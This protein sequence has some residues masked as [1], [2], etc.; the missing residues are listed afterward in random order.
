MYVYTPKQWREEA[1]EPLGVQG[2][3]VCESKGRGGCEVGRSERVS[4]CESKGWLTQGQRVVLLSCEPDR[5]PSGT[6][7]P[8]RYSQE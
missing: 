4:V 1:E 8:P 2:V 3:S 6:E 5:W 7:T